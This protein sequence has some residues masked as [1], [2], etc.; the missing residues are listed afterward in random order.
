MDEHLGL[1][2]QLADQNASLGDLVRDLSDMVAS[3]RQKQ[4]QETARMLNLETKLSWIGRLLA[5][6]GPLTS[7]DEV[8]EAINQGGEALG[9][10]D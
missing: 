7:M 4:E 9:G 2:Q 5:D 1:M 8:L 3:V 10:S 6:V